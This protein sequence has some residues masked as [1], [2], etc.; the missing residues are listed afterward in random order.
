MKYIFLLNSFSLKNKYNDVYNRIE[1]LAKRRELDYVIESNSKD[2]ST[3]D[4]LKKYKRSKNII[5]AIGGDGTINRVLN[6]IVGTDNILGFIPYGTGNDFYKAANELLEDGI[7]EIDLGKINNKYF[8]NVACFGIDAD[9]GNNENIIHSNII[10]EKSRYDISLIYHFLKYKVRPMKISISDTI[11]EDL[12]TTVCVCN[13]RY[14]GGGYKVGYKSLL[15]DNEF[16][17]YL[18]REMPK[19]KMIPLILGMNKGKHEKSKYTKKIATNKLL[20]E[21]K[22]DITCNVDGEAL[23]DKK[24]NIELIHNGIKIYFDK[25]MIKEFNKESK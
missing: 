4:I 8:I 11:Y 12:Y 15:K 25:S 2:V 22:N 3:E 17:V 23:T 24:F 16:E 7:N 21:S 19:I 9:I 20:I 1:K 13:G 14:Y 5:I 18:V 6:S 10:P